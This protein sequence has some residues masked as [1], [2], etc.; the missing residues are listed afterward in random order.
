MG[1]CVC[2]WERRGRSVNRGEQAGR[3]SGS[4]RPPRPRTLPGL[5]APAR[6]SGHIHPSPLQTS[7]KL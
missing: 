2:H 5:A 7:R 4:S 6:S 3:G 1:L